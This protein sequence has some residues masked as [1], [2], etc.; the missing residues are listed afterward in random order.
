[1][2][3]G[4]VAALADPSGVVRVEAATAIILIAKRD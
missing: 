3:P 2:T 1:V 4:L